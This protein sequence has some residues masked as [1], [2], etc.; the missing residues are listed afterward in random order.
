MAAS[1]LAHVAVNM[2]SQLSAREREWTSASARL[3]SSAENVSVFL[4]TSCYAARVSSRAL[5]S[6]L[7]DARAPCPQSCGVRAESRA[8][9]CDKFLVRDASARSRFHEAVEPRKRAALHVAVVEPERELVNVPGKMLRAGV[10]INA[11]DPAFQHGPHRFDAVGAD[12]V[13]H[14]LAC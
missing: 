3:Y 7:A 4:P 13:P 1:C 6:A 8:S 10:M 5:T 12:T 9:S 14:V 2:R 11:N